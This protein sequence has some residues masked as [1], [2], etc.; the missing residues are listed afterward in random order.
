MVLST[1]VVSDQ[2]IAARYQ[3]A[4]SLGFHIVLSC[5]GVAFPAMIFVAHR[6][7]LR[8]GDDIALS[9]AKRWSKV[10]AVL[11][12]VGAVSGTI[13]SFE[14]GLLW[15]GLMS[16]FGDVIGLPFA[17]EGIAFFVEAI[18][19]GIYLYGWGRLPG[20]THLYTLLPIMASGAF[21]TFC[22][23]A[24]NSWMN[25]PSGFRLEGGKVVGVDPLAAIFNDALPMQFLHMLL[26]AYIV[27]GFL[28]ASV[29]AA[30]MLR[31][32]HDHRHRL[33]FL[34]PFAFASIAAVMQPLVGHVA[35]MRLATQQPE[36]L[37]AMDLAVDTEQNA[38][39]TIGGVLVDGDVRGAVKIPGLGSLLARAGFDRPVQ[40]L[41]DFPVEDRPPVNIVHWSFQAMVALGTALAVGGSLFWWR[42]RRG[43]DL[44]ASKWAMRLAVLAG[45]AAV[46]TLELGWITTEVGRQ[47]WIVYRVLRVEDAVTSNS[48]VWISLAALVVVYGAMGVITV[49]VMRSMAARWRA[50]DG[51]D[52]PTPYGPVSS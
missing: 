11:F 32:R 34:V 52:L 33:G 14:M 42:R 51:D 37:A 40:G 16:R 15:P 4:L 31:G 28:V 50:G 1:I 23:L 20:R 45:P 26:A 49:R 30:G 39:L 48:G 46:L 13:L 8:D 19:I 41:N 3:M 25:A 2:L 36:K 9:L 47:P 27:T 29:Y 12:A 18:F 22:I 35:G 7:G 44:F 24:V 38:P 5:V 17:M 43:H 6:R 10:A 21:G